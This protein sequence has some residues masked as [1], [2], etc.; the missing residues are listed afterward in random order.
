MLRG[1]R[2]K[3]LE[4]EVTS[5][6]IIFLL[7]I[8]RITPPLLFKSFNPLYMLP[9]YIKIALIM[10]LSFLISSNIFEPYLIE[11]VSSLSAAPFALSILSEF[12][13]GSFFWFSLILTYGAMMTVFQLLDIQVGFNP[14]GIFNPAMNQSEPILS[15]AILIFS[16]LLFFA[17][18]IHYLIIYVISSTFEYY[19]ILSGYQDFSVN[20]SID[21]FTRQLVVSFML[22]APVVISIL[23]VEV[24]LGLCSRMMPQVNIYF[25]GL[26]AKVLVAIFMLGFISNYA[27][28][29]IRKIFTSNFLYWDSLY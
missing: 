14:S 7:V 8:T 11:K 28:K 22:V 12:F 5:F 17:L 20:K 25:V 3:I 13:I 18:D 29:V 16:M 9:K 26:P 27:E 10:Y 6:I 1:Y 23:W 21:F 2:V 4:G 15:R 24:V 19:P